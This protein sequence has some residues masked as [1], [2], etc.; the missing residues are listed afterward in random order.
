MMKVFLSWCGDI[1]QQIAR[2]VHDWLPII[3]QNVRP[4]MT[5]ADIEKGQGGVLKLRENLKHVILASSV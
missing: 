3:L 1:S 4:Y 5:P 2:E